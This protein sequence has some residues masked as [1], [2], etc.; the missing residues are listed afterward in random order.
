[1]TK[2]TVSVFLFVAL[3]VSLF[4]CGEKSEVAKTQA[5]IDYVSEEMTSYETYTT[6]LDVLAFME[7][8]LQEFTVLLNDIEANS[9]MT[10]NTIKECEANWASIAIESN[11][12]ISRIKV[13]TPSNE[14]SQ[15]W[16]NMI[17]FLACLDDVAHKLSNWD[18]NSDGE[19]TSSECTSVVQY[20]IDEFAKAENKYFQPF[21]EQFLA[22][23]EPSAPETSP[24]MGNNQNSYD[25]PKHADTSLSQ[26]NDYSGTNVPFTNQFG[27]ST[28]Q[29]A[30][31]GCDNYIANS[32][33][34]NCCTEHSNR[35]LDCNKYI[36][37]DAYWCISCLVEAADPTC[38]ECSKDATY[39]IKGISGQTEYYCADHY[40]EMKELLEWLENN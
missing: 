12:W 19:Y 14:Y 21:S 23:P 1:M 40:N 15:A 38:E 4:S 6:V 22:I 5:N 37:E 39:S 32:G 26:G 17:H 24:E 34:T 13:L 9:D 36:D 30:H 8:L 18:T 27:T 33:D 16:G 7:R 31:I 25:P 35:C 10:I 3:L 28:T 2:R 11:E 20:C 29:C